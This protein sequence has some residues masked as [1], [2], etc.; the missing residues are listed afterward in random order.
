MRHITRPSTKALIEKAVNPEGKPMKITDYITK[1]N[2]LYGNEP[3]ETEDPRYVPPAE[4]EDIKKAIPVSP[5]VKK[6]KK[7][8]YE[9]WA[10]Q[11]EEAPTKKAP[12]KVVGIKDSALY[13]LLENP[14]V[15]GV[16][17]GHETIMEIIN[18][19]QH[20]GLVK[21]PEEKI[22]HIAL[23]ADGDEFVG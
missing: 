15:F 23:L 4:I 8:K 17:L 16:E 2:K 3:D 18:L 5:L 7:W 21:K 20:S 19:I 22:D 11:Q 1:M 12:V 10:D 9:S 14:K 13:K 6:D